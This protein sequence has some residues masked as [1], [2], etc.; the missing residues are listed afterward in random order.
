MGNK[1]YS[2]ILKKGEEFDLPKI[3]AYIPQPSEKD[4]KRGYIVRYFA[5]KANDKS[6]PIY[7][8]SKGLYGKLSNIS[9][10]TVTFLDWRLTG[11]PKEIKKS[12][13]VSIRIA[14]ND[15]Y[16]IGLYLPNL[17]QFHQK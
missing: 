5:Q 13:S 9:Y 7:E 6:A 16:K 14:A 15:I 12:N 3:V 2:K 17:L 10:Y 4:Y 11:S 1:R 8:I